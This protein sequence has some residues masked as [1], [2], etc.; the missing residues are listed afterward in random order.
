MR[1]YADDGYCQNLPLGFLTI[2]VRRNLNP[3]F[4]T[5]PSA[6]IEVLETRATGSEL[7]DL[8]TI[9][10]DSDSGVSE[11]LFYYTTWQSFFYF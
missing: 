11:S 8:S 10:R 6:S 5:Q 1:F 7:Y 9:A 3:P 4:W 2:N